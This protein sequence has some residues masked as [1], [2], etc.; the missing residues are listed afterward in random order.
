MTQFNENTK[1]LK[2]LIMLHI[3]ESFYTETKF[4][5]QDLFSKCDQIRSFLQIWSHLLRKS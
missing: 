1:L 4:S 2:E 5:I 3:S